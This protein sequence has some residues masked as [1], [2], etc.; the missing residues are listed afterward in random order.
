VVY[1]KPPFGGPER[2]L[3][4]LARYTHRVAISNHRLQSLEQGRVSFAARDY[5]DHGRTKT[6]TLDAVEFIRRFL[7]HV[8]PSG[9]VRIR[10]FGFL[11]NRVRKQKLAL[12]RV[13]LGA[14]QPALLDSPASPDAHLEQPPRCP[15]C[16]LGR[17]I[18]TELLAIPWIEAQDTS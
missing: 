4:Y 7:L 10:Q 14:R 15:I 11:S 2:V 17:L 3:K 16:K 5:A 13:L 6:M 18:L 8:L 12:C 1:A 9:F